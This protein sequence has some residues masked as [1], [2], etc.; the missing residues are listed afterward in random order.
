MPAKAVCCFKRGYPKIRDGTNP[1]PR[2][3]R[4]RKKKNERWI[5]YWTNM[6]NSTRSWNK[7]KTLELKKI[8][9]FGCMFGF[10][11]CFS[12][13]YF[14]FISFKEKKIWDDQYWRFPFQKKERKYIKP[15]LLKCWTVTKHHQIS[16]TLN[17]LP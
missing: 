10:F 17:I 5:R 2:I 13:K 16:H 14:Q 15:P 9:I 12:T 4:Q 7:W 11:W 8:Y 1:I 6:I 3:T